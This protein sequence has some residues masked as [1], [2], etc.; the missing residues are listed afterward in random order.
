[1]HGR[2]RLSSTGRG[3]FSLKGRRTARC[4]DAVVLALW[5]VKPE[6]VP[7]HRLLLLLRP[8][9]CTK[10]QRLQEPQV[11]RERSFLDED[12]LWY[13]LLKAKNDTRLL[14]RRARQYLSPLQSPSWMRGLLG[15]SRCSPRR[16]VW[17][18]LQALARS[19]TK[20]Y[21]APKTKNAEN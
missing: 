15:R 9:L 14:V 21:I 12:I 7:L 3:R 1:V 5:R 6:H 10:T 8:R 18:Y 11:A 4:L 2:E 13:A 19:H 17:T 20:L 16:R